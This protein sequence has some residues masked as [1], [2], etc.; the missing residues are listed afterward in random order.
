MPS[1]ASGG[2]RCARGAHTYMQPKHPYTEH[3]LKI[4][5][6]LYADRYRYIHIHTYLLD[7]LQKDSG[8]DYH[9]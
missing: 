4:K 7:I 3:M 1:S 8:M 6:K 2:T 9:N 5:F